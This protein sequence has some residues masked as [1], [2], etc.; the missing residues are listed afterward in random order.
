M[1]TFGALVT[2]SMP[3]WSGDRTTRVL[4]TLALAGVLFVVVRA[5]VRR[6]GPVG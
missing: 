6:P 1:T 3:Y 5:A 4:H 2:L